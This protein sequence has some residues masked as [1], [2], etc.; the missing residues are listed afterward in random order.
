[1][2]ITLLIF[3]ILFF[4]T[5]IFSQIENATPIGARAMGMGGV[6]LCNSDVW[7]TN[8]NQG[9]I[10]FA[11]ESSLGLYYENRFG[12]SGL[13][14]K[15]IAGIYVS[16]FG[17][18]GLRMNYFGYS[19]YNTVITGISYGR[20]FGEYFSAGMQINYLHTQLSEGYGSAG[21][22]IA[23]LGLLAKPNSNLSIG[24]HIYNPTMTQYNQSENV[25]KI[26]TY[27]KLGASYN[28]DGFALLSVEIQ[29][30]IDYKPVYAV[31]VE[32]NI[33][34]NLVARTGISSNSSMLSLGL[35]YKYKK[36]RLDI[37]FSHHAYLGYSPYI[38][39]VYEFGST[40]KESNDE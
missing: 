33:V 13:G 15:S 5:A 38:S 37:A 9:A 24:A 1:M 30:D 16:N 40:V 14:Y 20:S 26:P 31:G 23:E 17:N 12:V 21:M 29:K 22:A 28:F 35:G 18:F 32:F 10:G 7:S 19:T 4:N 34:N 25:E 11:Q 39:F 8:N 36:I 6:S 2:R 27:L 3:S